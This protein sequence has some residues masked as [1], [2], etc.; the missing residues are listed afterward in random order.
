MKRMLFY[1]Y[2]NFEDGESNG[3]CKKIKTQKSVFEKNGHIVDFSF[4]IGEDYYINDGTRNILLQ[5]KNL[6]WTKPFAEKRLRKY[7]S[8]RKY[9]CAYLR[10][11]CADVQ[12]IKLLRELRKQG[13]RI[14]LE[15]PTFPYDKEFSKNVSDKIYLQI[16]KVH[17]RSLKK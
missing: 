7:I 14:I 8:A 17:R 9:D 2:W 10:Y 11:N 5:K 15:I 4:L 16:D 1:T 12:F 3:I 6:I 13:A